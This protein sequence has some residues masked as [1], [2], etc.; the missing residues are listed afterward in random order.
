MGVLCAMYRVLCTVCHVPCT[1]Y[2]VPCIMYH[3]LCTVYC[4][5]CVLCVLCTV[6]YVYCV[7]YTVAYALYTIYYSLYSCTFIHQLVLSSMFCGASG[8]QSSLC[9]SY[10]PN[11]RKS[12]WRLYTSSRIN[13]RRCQYTSALFNIWNVVLHPT[14]STWN[15]RTFVNQLWDFRNTH[16]NCSLLSKSLDAWPRYPGKILAFGTLWEIGKIL[17]FQGSLKACIGQCL[18]F[19]NF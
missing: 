17:Q 4:V 13:T 14:T 2:H 15:I 3:V 16:S 11:L 1:M 19:T 10:L 5:L 7:L 18:Q 9:V 6:Y 12:L 8:V